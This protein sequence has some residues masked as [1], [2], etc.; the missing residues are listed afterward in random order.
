MACG[1]PYCET[2]G[3]IEAGFRAWS[4]ARFWPKRWAFL[5]IYSFLC[6]KWNEQKRRDSLSQL[7]ND[8]HLIA[9]SSSSF[10]E[11]HRRRLLLPLDRKIQKR[12]LW[13]LLH[14]PVMDSI[15]THR[16][17]T[18]P[19]P[20]TLA[21]MPPIE[22]ALV[23]RTFSAPALERSRT[24]YCI[25]QSDQLSKNLRSRPRFWVQQRELG[26]APPQAP[27]CSVME[28]D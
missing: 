2:R 4:H 5:W 9:R 16:S 17:A 21:K 18:P 20:R 19:P 25:D 28:A 10:S 1:L 11:I 7:T 3:N 12:N 23:I 22:G 24:S 27:K 13:L 15:T 14:R 6:S 26:P 8:D